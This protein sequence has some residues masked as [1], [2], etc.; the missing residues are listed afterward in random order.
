M[1]ED[2]GLLTRCFTSLD[3]RL[4]KYLDSINVSITVK[5]TFTIT[6]IGLLRYLVK[7]SGGT[8]YSVLDP[9]DSSNISH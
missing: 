2:G 8:Y 5:I 7:R 3:V 9:S 1:R 6:L 4:L